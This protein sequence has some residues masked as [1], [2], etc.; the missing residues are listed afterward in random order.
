MASATDS[1]FDTTRRNYKR[2]RTT[3]TGDS[4][5]TE[6]EEMSMEHSY[7]HNMDISIAN[8]TDNDDNKVSVDIA[9]FLNESP[10]DDDDVVAVAA[11]RRNNEMKMDRLTKRLIDIFVIQRIIDV[12]NYV[13]TSFTWY[14]DSCRQAGVLGCGIKPSS[15]MTTRAIKE[16]IES[17]IHYKHSPQAIQKLLGDY[18]NRMKSMPYLPINYLCTLLLCDLTYNFSVLCA[19][20]DYFAT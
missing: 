1:N 8:N 18:K 12:I 15:R 20:I 5:A 10:D 14:C 9:L 19:Y 17:D 6:I 16:H 11:V 13:V 4:I 2:Q 7:N 3:I